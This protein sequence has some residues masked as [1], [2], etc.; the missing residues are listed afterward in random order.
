M[1]AECVAMVCLG[2]NMVAYAPPS[3]SERV[4]QLD[5]PAIHLHVPVRQGVSHGVLARGA[6]HYRYTYLPGMGGNIVLAAHDVTPVLGKPHGP[7]YHIN[8]LRKGDTATFTVPY[9][10]YRYVV[11]GIRTVVGTATGYLRPNLRV[12]KL[13]LAMCWPRHSRA[14]RYLVTLRRVHG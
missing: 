9:G 7:F 3:P 11:T 14:Q 5:V 6:G 10:A 2:T 4:G 8:R 1:L 12:E 13:V